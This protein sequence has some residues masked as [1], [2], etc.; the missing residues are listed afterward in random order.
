MSE[1][2]LW[3]S[4]YVVV[5]AA[6]GGLIGL[7]F[8]VMTLLASRPPVPTADAG[9]AFASPTIVHFSVTLFLSALMSVPWHSIA[10]LRTLSLVFAIGGSVYMAVVARRMRRQEAYEPEFEDWLFHLL[11][12]WVGYLLLFVSAGLMGTHA[13]AALFSVAMAA[14]LLLLTG[15]HNAWDAVAYHL[16]TRAKHEDDS[17]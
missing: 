2:A 4:F 6:A 8:V 7:Q 3:D 14:L 9:A 11:L 16:L 13:G 5:G 15:I 12:P 17:R 10:A 1:L